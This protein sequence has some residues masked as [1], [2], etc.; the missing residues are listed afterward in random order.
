MATLDE[1]TESSM[2][3]ILQEPKN[4]LIKQYK[5]LFEME[6]VNLRITDSAISAI[7]REAIARKSGARGL[8]AILESCLIDIMFELPSMENVTECVIGEEVV[9]NHEKPILIYEQTRKQA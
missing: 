5:K 4:A 3:R 9:L 2:I 7:A 6:N 1:L 8:R